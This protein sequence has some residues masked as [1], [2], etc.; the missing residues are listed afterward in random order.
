MHDLGTLADGTDS[1]AFYVND[2][3]QV[4]GISFTNNVVNPVTGVPTTD[5]FVWENGKMIDL[6][7]LGGAYAIGNY[8]NEKGQVAGMSDLAGDLNA[9]PFLWTKGKGM[10][11]SGHWEDFLAVP[12]G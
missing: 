11:D 4:N 2:L 5:P 7:T 10:Q 8:F 6:G 3:G 9:H 12:N 1:V